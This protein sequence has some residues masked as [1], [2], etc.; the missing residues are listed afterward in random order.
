MAVLILLLIGSTVYDYSVNHQPTKERRILLCFSVHHNLQRLLQTDQGTNRLSVLDGIRVLAISWIVLGHRFEQNLQFPNMTLINLEKVS[1]LQHYY[2]SSCQTYLISVLDGIRGLVISWIVLAHRFEQNLQ[3]P[4]MTLINLEK[5]SGLQHYYCSSCQTYLISV[6]DGI[7]GLVISWIVL[8]HRFEQNLQFPN[9]TLINLEKVSGLQHY[10]CSSCQT[11]LIS[12]LDG[13]RVLAISWIVLCHRFE[14]NLQFPNMTLIN[15]EK[16]T[17]AWFM[18][19]ILNMMMAV[20]LFFLLSGCLL[21]YHFL[22]ERK[23]GKQFNLIHFYYKRH[24]RLTP[25]L[26][27]VMAAEACL[28]YYLSDGPL[29]KRLIG[30]RM[31]SCLDYWWTGL[32]YISNY[33]NPYRICVLQTWYLS[34]DMQ[35]YML[36]PLLLLPLARSAS[37]GLVLLGGCYLATTAAAFANAYYQALPAGSTVT[38]Y[39]IQGSVSYTGWD[40]SMGRENEALTLVLSTLYGPSTNR[41]TNRIRNLPEPLSMC[42][43]SERISYSQT[44]RFHT[45]DNISPFEQLEAG[46]THHLPPRLHWK[47]STGTPQHI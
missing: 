30:Y 25:A 36:S 19:P 15:L 16:Y 7:R 39:V 47:P 13:I 12:V 32:L 43:K 4:N 6:L 21:C 27:A 8:A 38:M 2:C 35:L 37:R 45:S 33:V 17:T 1:G 22:Q 31:S 11:Y 28:L 9:M 14:Q 42:K 20:E 44:L 24:I 5:V 18:S 41:N 34:A 46:K 26:V 3:F 29:W 23:R 40:E 10:Y